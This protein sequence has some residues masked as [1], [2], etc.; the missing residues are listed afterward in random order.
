MQLSLKLGLATA[1][2]ISATLATYGSLRLRQEMSLF[3]QDMRRDH[4]NYGRAL[5]LA[6]RAVA[7]R[8]GIDEAREMIEAA[9]SMEPRLTI[10]FVAGAPPRA[11]SHD[12]RNRS[13]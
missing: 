13:A 3:E 2:G 4:Q 8:H 12:A 10:E 1:L 7:R 9:N 6:A 5:G 11:R